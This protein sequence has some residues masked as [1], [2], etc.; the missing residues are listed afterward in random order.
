VLG[1]GRRGSM[2]SS[3]ASRS[4]SSMVMRGSGSA[5]RAR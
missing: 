4:C 2:S 5:R 3:L 1:F